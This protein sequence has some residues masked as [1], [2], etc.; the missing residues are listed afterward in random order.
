VCIVYICIYA[1]LYTCIEDISLTSRASLKAASV[2]P[3]QA[4][5][6]RLDSSG[7]PSNNKVNIVPEIN[8]LKNISI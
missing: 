6:S 5:D 2:D 4:S 1:Y 3:P 8:A 7:K